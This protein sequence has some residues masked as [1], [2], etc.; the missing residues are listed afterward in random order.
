MVFRRVSVHNFKKTFYI[1]ILLV[2]AFSIGSSG[3]VQSAIREKIHVNDKSLEEIFDSLS[4]VE[5]TVAHVRKKISDGTFDANSGIRSGSSASV[6]PAW[7][8]Q[9]HTVDHSILTT[10]SND[11]IVNQLLAMN[12]IFKAHGLPEPLHLAYPWG[13]HDGRVVSI[14]SQYRVS[15]RTASYSSPPTNPDW[16]RLP[17]VPIVRGSELSVI[18][19]EIDRAIQL[20][21]LM[22]IFTHYVAPDG[23]CTPEMLEAILDYVIYQ[24]N[25]GNLQV[26]TMSQAYEQYNGQKAVVVFSFD[27]AWVTDYT[28]V[29]PM[30]MERGLAGTSYI[31]ADAVIYEGSNSPFLNWDMIAEMA[32]IN[33]DT[34]WPGYLTV[35]GLDNTIYYR[36]WRTLDTWATWNLLPGTTCDSPAAAVCDN[37]LHL[38]VRSLDNSLFHGYVNIVDNGFSGWSLISGLTSSAPTLVS[39][40]DTLYLVVRGLEGQ[41]WYRQYDCS[42]QLWGSWVM[43]PSGLTADSIGASVI[44]GKLC[45]VV[46]AID[47]LSLWFGHID[48]SNQVFSGWSLI[49]GLTPSAPTL[50]N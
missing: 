2:F 48:L 29:W 6:G 14:V 10:L 20:K 24:Q 5:E 21:G 37:K 16:Y 3:L 19:N 30:F 46:Q 41:I 12:Y 42:S 39:D 26:M 31:F 32:H 8:F 13:D 36:S 28:T 27:D 38:I 1:V 7:D 23:D 9:D 17:V 18:I 40:E 49:S 47:G 22:N 11:S 44:D 4:D 25:L 43:L 45:M 33:Q 34:G 15:G 35:Q 50:T